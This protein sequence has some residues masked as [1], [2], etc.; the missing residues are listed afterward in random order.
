MYYSTLAFRVGS[1][2]PDLKVDFGDF[3]AQALSGAS[4]GDWLKLIA[5]ARWFNSIAALDNAVPGMPLEEVAFW[6]IIALFLA[7]GN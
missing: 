7:E 2:T 5:W 3:G 1:L 6:F 4:L